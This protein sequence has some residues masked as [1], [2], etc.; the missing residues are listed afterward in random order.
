[1]SLQQIFLEFA[2]WLETSP[3]GFLF[4]MV[5][6]FVIA[7]VVLGRD[8]IRA[9][10]VARELVQA[11]AIETVAEPEATA[12][13]SAA[14][15]R[16]ATAMPRILIPVDGSE[17]ALRAVRHVVN[18]SLSRCGVEAHLLHVRTPFTRYV[19]GL[20]SK[21]SRDAH[22]REM[23]EQA[24]AKARELLNRYSVPHSVH[25]DVGDRAECIHRMAQRLRVDK[26]VMGTARKNSLTRVI[27]DSVTS[28]VLEIVQVPVE[29]IAGGNI[30]KLE[31]Y[32]VPAGIGTALAA[33][34]VAV[35]D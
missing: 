30:S 4:L 2:A 29:V 11:R 18:Q 22:H 19:A 28:R 14:T 32:G 8:A 27:Q 21:K 25:M 16:P 6:P 20:T 12:P 17:N 33:L 34:T 26:I 1:M 10:R 3:P 23:A 31:R 35:A 9:R 15:R 7:I 13:V 24:L 5:L